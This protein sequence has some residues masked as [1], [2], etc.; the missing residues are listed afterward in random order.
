MNKT[1]LYIII[2]AL[3]AMMFPPI[4]TGSLEIALAIW[5]V[6]KIAL[7]ILGAAFIFELINKTNNNGEQDS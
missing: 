7:I 1:T 4:I 2:F 3:L 5:E 6:A